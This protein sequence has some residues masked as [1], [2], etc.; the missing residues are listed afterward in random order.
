MIRL[1][2]ILLI[3]VLISLIFIVDLDS[4]KYCPFSHKINL[5][6]KCRICDS[7]E[8]KLLIEHHNL[9]NSELLLSIYQ[10]GKS[11]WIDHPYGKIEN[12]NNALNE[13]IIKFN[14]KNDSLLIVNGIDFKIAV[15]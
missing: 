7:I 2:I 11:L 4:T 13:N 1:L 12:F 5:D 8:D 6:W 9:D 10:D 3:I 15:Q 14:A